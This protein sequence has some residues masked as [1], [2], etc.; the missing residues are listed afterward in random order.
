MHDNLI[1]LSINLSVV[2]MQMK[3]ENVSFTRTVTMN[4]FV[5]YMNVNRLQAIVVDTFVFIHETLTK[6]VLQI[7][8][9]VLKIL[10]QNY[11]KNLKSFFF[12]STT[13]IVMFNSLKMGGFMTNSLSSFF[14]DLHT[15][16]SNEETFREDFLVIRLRIIRKP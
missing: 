6:T 2:W 1:V 16:I 10:L 14:R 11:H 5:E 12:L 3:L 13:C 15:T 4:V 9:V 7:F 8:V